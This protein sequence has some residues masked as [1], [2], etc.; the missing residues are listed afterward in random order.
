MAQA[1]AFELPPAG[2]VG[3]MSNAICIFL[4]CGR[5]GHASCGNLFD[6]GTAPAHRMIL[7]IQ[8]MR[9]EIGIV[10]ATGVARLASGMDAPAAIPIAEITDLAV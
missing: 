9:D 10:A 2:G 8:P 6:T 1:S 4:Q 3:H 7:S 5:K